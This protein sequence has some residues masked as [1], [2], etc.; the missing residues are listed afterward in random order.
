MANPQAP[1]L[2]GKNFAHRDW[3]RG[4]TRGWRPYV[5]EIYTRAAAPQRQVVAIAVPILEDDGRPLGILGMHVQLATFVEWTA[6][7]GPEGIVYFVDRNGESIGDPHAS[8]EP[9]LQDFSQSPAVQRALQGAQGVIVASDPT[10][11]GERVISYAPVRGYGW[12]ALTVESSRPR[13]P[14]ETAT[15]DSSSA[16][17]V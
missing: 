9:A 4:V 10:G 11:G 15:C 16:S 3:Y 14:R 12:G 7:L 13:L 1:E 8:K 2:L 17:T 6:T 5:S